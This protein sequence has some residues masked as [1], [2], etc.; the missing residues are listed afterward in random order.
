MK[1]LESKTKEDLE[2]EKLFLEIRKLNSPF[3]KNPAVLLPWLIPII[4]I[5]ISWYINKD[6]INQKQELKNLSLELDTKV[7]EAKK[8]KQSKS[9][10][11][12]NKFIKNIEDSISIIQ[13][14]FGYFQRTQ[15]TLQDSLNRERESFQV[16]LA[17]L[18]DKHKI[19]LEGIEDSFNLTLSEIE[20]KQKYV[21]DS[22][23]ARNLVQTNVYKSEEC[24]IQIK[25]IYRNLDLVT[26]AILPYSVAHNND[27]EKKDRTAYEYYITLKQID[28]YLSAMELLLADF[29]KTDSITSTKVWRTF[30]AKLTSSLDR[31]NPIFEETDSVMHWKQMLMFEVFTGG[32]VLTYEDRGFVIN[33]LEQISEVL[34]ELDFIRRLEINYSN[35]DLTR[36]PEPLNRL[37]RERKITN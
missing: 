14:R 7:L 34:R 19:K 13:T 25:S 4:V 1:L 36:I 12:L 16:Y 27:K 33:K 8:D 30:N 11:S 26:E 32:K 28:K 22:I 2:K 3:Y 37:G 15:N 17:T 23:R 20:I 9:I 21:I 6:Y 31:I 29:I 5:L 10:D 24:L 35:G 18:S